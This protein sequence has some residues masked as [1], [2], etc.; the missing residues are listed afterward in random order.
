MVL[1]KN[2]AKSILDVLEG[3]SAGDPEIEDE[4]RKIYVGASRAER[5]LAIALPKIQA[6]RLAALLE[7]AKATFE[8][9]QI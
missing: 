7:A 2:K 5:L 1:T 8:T 9:H 6:P 4:A 3:K